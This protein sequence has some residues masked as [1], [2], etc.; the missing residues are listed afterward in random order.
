MIPI[1]KIVNINKKIYS[2]QVSS[3]FIYPESDYYEYFLI[4]E[5]ENR[6]NIIKI[7]DDFGNNIKYSM[8]KDPIT[9]IIKLTVLLY[10]TEME[11][12]QKYLLIYLQ[13][14]SISYVINNDVFELQDNLD[15]NGL[16]DISYNFKLNIDD[17]QELYELIGNEN[18]ISLVSQQD[19]Q[20]DYETGI[21][22]YNNGNNNSYSIIRPIIDFESLNNGKLIEFNFH[23][24]EIEDDQV[25]LFLKSFNDNQIVI[26]FEKHYQQGKQYFDFLFNEQDFN[27][28]INENNV[29]NKVSIDQ[30][31]TLKFQIRIHQDKIFFYC[32]NIL[33]KSYNINP[34]DFILSDLFFQVGLINSFSEQSLFYLHDINVYPIYKYKIQYSDNYSDQ[35]VEY[36]FD[37]N[38]CEEFDFKKFSHVETPTKIKL[39]NITFPYNYDFPEFVGESSIDIQFKNYFLSFSK[40]VSI[41]NKI[42]YNKDVLSNI[43]NYIWRQ[44]TPN[45]IRE[46]QYEDDKY[47]WSEFVH[48]MQDFIQKLDLLSK[49]FGDLFHPFQTDMY[50]KKTLYFRFKSLNILEDYFNMVENNYQIFT[51]LSLEFFKEIL[52]YYV[53]RGKTEQMKVIFDNQFKNL[54]QSLELYLFYFS[55]NSDIEILPY[56]YP[57][58]L[59]SFNNFIKTGGLG[60]IFEQ[61]K[62]QLYDKNISYFKSLRKE[63]YK[64]YKNKRLMNDDYEINNI[65]DDMID[66]MLKNQVYRHIIVVFDKKSLQMNDFR[67]SLNKFFTFIKNEFLPQNMDFLFLENVIEDIDTENQ[68]IFDFSQLRFNYLKEP[69]T[70]FK[71]L[72]NSS[73]RQGQLKKDKVKNNQIYIKSEFHLQI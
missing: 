26:R 20:N 65:I 25:F 58:K 22:I 10:R 49:N 54:S 16:Q 63:L 42:L 72:N 46:Q 61:Q 31:P 38:D 62:T 33:L 28:W 50:L 21:R 12:N 73:I 6:T 55:Q 13:R 36:D 44:T 34:Q 5:Q 68:N 7:E 40:R 47:L 39:E 2:K 71:N 4:D 14:P 45:F 41:L 11:D 19:S 23:E 64:S 51:L 8:E 27:T 9:N 18:N 43:E 35:F 3:I 48:V 52:E 37:S 69:E 32:N 59:D 30:E 17:V 15:L 56:Q 66:G 60:K 24:S 53:H 67:E 70:F 1:N 29:S 57:T